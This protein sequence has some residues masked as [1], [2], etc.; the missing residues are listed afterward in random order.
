M[1]LVTGIGLAVVLIA[2]LGILH[3]YAIRRARFLVSQQLGSLTAQRSEDA[4]STQTARADQLVEIDVFSK[5]IQADTK[6]EPFGKKRK[7]PQKR[8]IPTDGRR[9]AIPN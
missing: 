7:M 3:V 4:K 2:F 8:P 5:N 1:S 6:T 9:W